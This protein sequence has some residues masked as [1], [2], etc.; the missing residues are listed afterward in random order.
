MSIYR[1]QAN[2]IY[3]HP[4]ELSRYKGKVLLIVNTASRCGYSRQ[5]ADLELLYHRYREQGFEILGFPCNQFNE[6]EPGCHAEV[7]ECY[8]DR[9][10]VTFSLFE[11]VEVRGPRA[12]P[13]F[14]YLTDRAPFVGIE[15]QTPNGQWM[16]NF[17]LDK[18]P[19]IYAGDGIKWNFTKFLID[20][21]GNVAGRY[22]TVAEPPEIEP[23]IVSL[24]GNR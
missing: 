22:E 11:K 20:R 1:F 8:V 12:H 13:L 18:H 7:H 9:L 15:T 5:L 14:S 23:A 24:L 16:K 2:T 21:N 19:D 4:V 3:G 17:L 10:G 6:K